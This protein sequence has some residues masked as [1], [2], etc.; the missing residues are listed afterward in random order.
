MAMEFINGAMEKYMKVDGNKVK[1]MDMENIKELI[2]SMK[3]NLK[4]ICI[5][6]RG[7]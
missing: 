3:D 5:K 6:D 1:D 2:N 4:M 7:Y